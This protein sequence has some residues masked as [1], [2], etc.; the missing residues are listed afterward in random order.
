MLDGEA[1]PSTDAGPASTDASS[2]AETSDAASPD[3]AA[4]CPVFGVSSPLSFSLAHGA[5][6]GSDHPDVVVHVPDGYDACRPQGAIVFF[7][8]FNN[9]VVNVVGTVSTACTPGGPARTPLHLVEQLDAVHVNA[10]L[11]AVELRYDLATG[12]PGALA[13]DGGL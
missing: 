5:F 9:C 6:P 8:G 7:H 12:D 4:S 10:L 13:L 11:I 2:D 1:G 3:A